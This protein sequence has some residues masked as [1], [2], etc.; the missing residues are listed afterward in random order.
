M[1]QWDYLSGIRFYEILLLTAIQQYSPMFQENIIILLVQS[2]EDPPKKNEDNLNTK[3]NSSGISW[4]K[5][6]SEIH[7]EDI[8]YTRDRPH[9]VSL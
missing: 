6:T 4:C 9:Y 7:K 8:F 2:S 3:D 5:L 1:T